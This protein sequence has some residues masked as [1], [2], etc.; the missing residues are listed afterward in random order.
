MRQKRNA[1]KVLVGNL[2]EIC[3]M[4]ELGINRKIL[5]K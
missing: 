1:Q 5:L 3:L 2:M 4:E